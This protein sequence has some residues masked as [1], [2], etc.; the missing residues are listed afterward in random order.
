MHGYLKALSLF[1]IFLLTGC[2]ASPQPTVPAPSTS[3]I[4][5]S[6]PPETTVSPT[7][8]PDPELL[9]Q[10]QMASDG[11]ACFE[12]N[13]FTYESDLYR[14]TSEDSQIQ[15]TSMGITLTLPMEWMNRVEI[16]ASADEVFVTNRAIIDAN[17]VQFLAAEEENDMYGWKD[18]MFRIY[19]VDTD[20]YFEG[21]PRN[22]EI[23][24]YLGETDTHFYYLMTPETQYEVSEQLQWRSKLIHHIGED[25]YYELFGDLIVTPDMIREMVTIRDETTGE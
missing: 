15:L 6:I 17:I 22:P 18:Y 11:F 9:Y 21:D 2:T 19:R 7:T 1:L 14:Y 12:A 5:T 10:E 16:V 24:V 4:E 8:A 23:E 20:S 25:A 13:P 3:Q